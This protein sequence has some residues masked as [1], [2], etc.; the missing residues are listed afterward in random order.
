MTYDPSFSD[1]AFAKL[2]A[3]PKFGDVY[4]TAA[5]EKG[6]L[7]PDRSASLRVSAVSSS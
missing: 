4:Q 1:T 3:W 7:I 6:T 5:L 2:T